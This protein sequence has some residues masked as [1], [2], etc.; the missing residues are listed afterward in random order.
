MSIE[1]YSTAHIN[2]QRGNAE[3]SIDV[4]VEYFSILNDVRLSKIIPQLLD[5]SP[6]VKM[7]HLPLSNHLPLS[8]EYYSTGPIVGEL[9]EQAS[10]V[11][12]SHELFYIGQ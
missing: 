9:I 10:Y 2:T 1:K 5:W 4:A 8:I 3:L 11:F 7:T 12:K 6:T